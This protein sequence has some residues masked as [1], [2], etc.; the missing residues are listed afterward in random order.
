MCVTVVDN[1]DTSCLGRARGR[2]RL[3][4]SIMHIA[5][6]KVLNRHKDIKVTGSYLHFENGCSENGWVIKL[7]T[8]RQKD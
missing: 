3:L 2:C 8:W 7:K 1:E 5:I 6:L 4:P